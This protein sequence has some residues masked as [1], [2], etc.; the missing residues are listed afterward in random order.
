MPDNPQPGPVPRE[1]LAYFRA[2][3]YRPA[4]DY[5]DVWRQEHA[6][7]FTVAKAMEMDVLTS[8]RGELDR[9]LADGRTF[10]DFKRDLTPTLQK[11][12]W[13]GRAPVTDP[14]TAGT[15]EAQLGSPRRLKTIYDANLRTARAAGQW[16]R[17]QR[18]KR[19]LPYLLY[20]QSTAEERRPEHEAKVGT[21]LPID[22]PFWDEWMPPN[23][24]GCKCAVRQLTESEA[25]R[26]GGVSP[27]PRI[28]R[29][30]YTNTRTGRTERV[31]RGI[32]PGWNTNPGKDR[33][34]HLVPP[35]LG[36]SPLPASFPGPAQGGTDK[37][38]M[39][40]PRQWT[41]PEPAKIPPAANPKAAV[42]D[43][44]RRFGATSGQTVLFTDKTGT[45]IPI[46]P[47]LFTNKKTGK[48]K[49]A[50]EGRDT[51]LP[52][53]EQTLR[54]PDEIWIRWE[55]LGK[56]WRLKRSYIAR[57]K[58]EEGK[59]GGLGVFTLSKDGWKG[60][61]IFPPMT[62]PDRDRSQIE[63]YL[64]SERTGLLIYSRTE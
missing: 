5:R 35:P 22:D 29:D 4:F 47:A 53:L 33:L 3:G 60:S 45:P 44:L 42:D 6:A 12:G 31:P 28:P 8:I 50:K 55:Q 20:L 57:I 48:F 30:T 64:E 14:Q 21:I 52:L 39:P 25:R 62:G 26:R 59:V 7:A 1:A 24:W 41:G 61:T 51:Y 40:P 37:P 34:G 27:T 13:W 32:D 46:G 58:T 63:E 2:K 19:A 15:A 10:R 38:P 43:F 36:G 54:D 23:G 16:E 9:A 18:T 49:A 11:L 17:A 56:H